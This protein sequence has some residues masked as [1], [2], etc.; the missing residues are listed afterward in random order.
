M[1]IMRI[2]Q[3]GSQLGAQHVQQ[4][5]WVDS[6]AHHEVAPAQSVT[7][8]LERVR[9]PPGAALFSQGRVHLLDSPCQTVLQAPAVP[10][11]GATTLPYLPRSAGVWLPHPPPGALPP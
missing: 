10:P 5:A 9:G 6:K 7:H 3:E 2:C 8:L 4:P 1:L 11:A